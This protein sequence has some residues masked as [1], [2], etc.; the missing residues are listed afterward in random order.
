[1][2]AAAVQPAVLS[3]DAFLEALY[4]FWEP[5]EVH[6]WAAERRGALVLVQLRVNAMEAVV[7]VAAVAA[8]STVALAHPAS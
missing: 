8:G 3:K 4:R 6:L 5:V 2:A 1:M 7:A